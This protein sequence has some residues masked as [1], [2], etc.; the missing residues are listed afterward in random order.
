MSKIATI[1]ILLIGY[2]KYFLHYKK[3][4]KMSKNNDFWREVTRLQKNAGY[5]NGLSYDPDYHKYKKKEQPSQTFGSHHLTLESIIIVDKKGNQHIAKDIT[6]TTGYDYQGRPSN[7]HT[8][9]KYNCWYKGNLFIFQDKDLSFKNGQYYLIEPN[10]WTSSN[11][12]GT[13]EFCFKTCRDVVPMSYQDFLDGGKVVY[14]DN[15]I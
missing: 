1:K 4:Y 2:K 13:Y 15:P 3:E 6:K 11:Y 9:L 12:E 7:P 14:I 8:I 5:G 10:V